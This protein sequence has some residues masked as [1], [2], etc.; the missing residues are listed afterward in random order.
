M[1]ARQARTHHFGRGAFA[2]FAEAAVPTLRQHGFSGLV[3]VPTQRLGLPGNADGANQ[4]ARPL[5][6]FW[7]TVRRLAGEGMEFGGH[8][9]THADLTGSIRLPAKRSPVAPQTCRNGSAIR[10]RALRSLRTSLFGCSR[11]NPAALPRGVWNP[12][13][14]CPPRR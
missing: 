3:F 14:Y 5:M 6:G 10:L 2:D 7:E 8:S 13:G 12:A 1:K 4:P 9:R 11:Y